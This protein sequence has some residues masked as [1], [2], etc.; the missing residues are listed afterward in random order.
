LSEGKLGIWLAI[1]GCLLILGWGTWPAV[2]YQAQDSSSYL[3][4]GT[5]VAI[6]GPNQAEGVVKIQPITAAMSSATTEARGAGP[7]QPTAITDGQGYLYEEI[8]SRRNRLVIYIEL[9]KRI[10]ER[11]LNIT[12]IA[13]AARLNFGMT[14]KCIEVLQSNGLIWADSGEGRRY[15]ATDKGL[16]FMRN[17]EQVLSLLGSKRRAEVV[18]PA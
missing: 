10:S 15:F 6:S 3:T 17:A 18:S 7:P 1:V 14:K 13:L 2:Q 9:I 8:R 11:P 4:A 5:P 12:E 16:L